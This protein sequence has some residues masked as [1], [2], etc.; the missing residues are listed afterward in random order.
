MRPTAVDREGP[1]DADATGTRR[2]R[3][4]RTTVAPPWRQRSQAEPE[5]EARPR[6]PLASLARAPARDSDRPRSS[7][8]A[9]WAAA[10]RLASAS[11]EDDSTRQGTGKEDEHGEGPHRAR[12]LARRVYQWPERRP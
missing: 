4:A 9:P 12:S 6:R 5:G 1:P 3:P 11:G 2:A 10:S 7:A 8:T